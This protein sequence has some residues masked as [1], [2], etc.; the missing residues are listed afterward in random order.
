MARKI[1]RPKKHIILDLDETIV[2]TRFLQPYLSNS[3]GRKYLQDN[4]TDIQSTTYSRRVDIML[5]NIAK[6]HKLTFYTNSPEGYARLVIQKHNLPETQIIGN[7]KKPNKELLEKIISDSG[8]RK[9]RT[10]LIGDSARDIL[11][12]HQVSIVPIGVTWG[13]STFQQLAEA[14]AK[15]IITKP[16]ELLDLFSVI[17]KTDLEYVPRKK[18]NRKEFFTDG[19]YDPE[20]EHHFLEE[21]FPWNS[22]DKNDFTSWVLSFKKTKD[23]THD[24]IKETIKEQYFYDGELINKRYHL[25]GNLAVLQ[26]QLIRLVHNLNLRGKTEIMAAPNSC[27]HYCYK[28]DINQLTS[29]VIAEKRGNDFYPQRT[30]ERVHPSQESHSSNRR[31][32]IYDHLE[33]IGIDEDIHYLTRAENLVIFDDIFTTGTQAKA[34]GIIAREKGFQGNIHFV[35]LGKTISGY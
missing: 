8:I 19:N 27:P 18:P 10:Y 29:G 3:D 7:A 30:F 20:F 6:H 15:E 33:T 23:Y 1:I 2:N 21:Y 22:G 16:E 14:E 13:Y 35:T 17:T 5:H 34:L 26:S 12:A 25:K 11:N 32:N 9:S 31:N 24:E 4:I 28:S